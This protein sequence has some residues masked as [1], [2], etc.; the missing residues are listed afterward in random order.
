ME[1]VN[2]SLIEPHWE[3]VF[4]LVLDARDVAVIIGIWTICLQRVPLET[5]NLTGAAQRSL[6][7]VPNIKTRRA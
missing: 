1:V 3:W 6:T 5:G 7:N 2:F 4:S